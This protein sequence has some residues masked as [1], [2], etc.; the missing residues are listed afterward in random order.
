MSLHCTNT[1]MDN[2]VQVQCEDGQFA[3]SVY[4]FV[5][6]QE[7]RY[8]GQGPRFTE[9]YPYSQGQQ[10]VEVQEGSAGKLLHQMGN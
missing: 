1:V 2:M 3:S 5:G 9:K 7:S 10:L 4:M 8:K 6:V